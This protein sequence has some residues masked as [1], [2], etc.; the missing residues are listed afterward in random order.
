LVRPQTPTNTTV[1]IYDELGRLKAVITPSGDAAIY[2]YDAAGNIVSI[3]RQTTATVS[4]I[5]FT[6]DKGAVGTSVTIY[7]TGFSLTPT[8]NSVSFNG[9]AA[10]V[11][12]ASATQLIVAVPAGA[13]TGPITVTT[14]NGSATS[15]TSFEVFQSLSITGFT[16]VIGTPGNAVQING[17]GFDPVAAN[18]QLKFNIT[19]A[20]AGSAT[21]TTIDTTVPTG[22]TSGHI[23][24]TTGAGTAVSTAD[25][26]VPPSPF[27]AA[28]VDFTGRIALGE[29]KPLSVV[30]A[31]HIAL[32]VFD[33]TA[34]QRIAFQATNSTI[35]S[36][37]VTVMNP[38]G[39]NLLNPTSFSGNWF[40][41]PLT[42]PVTGTYTIVV[43]PNSTFTGT[44]NL[45]LLTV[46]VDISGTIAPGVP[47]TITPTPGQNATLTFNATAGDRIS[48]DL[49]N[50][51][52]S[53]SSVTV[54]KPD[55]TTLLSNA[56][57]GT[58]GVFF[59]ATTL[60]VSGSY[61]IFIDPKFAASGS[62][63][64]GLYMPVDT[65]GT[66]VI[67][68][69]PVV[70]TIASPGQNAQLT[71]TG[72]AGQ[73]IEV[74]WFGEVSFS[75]RP[76]ILKPDGTQLADDYG[77]STG[78][79]IYQLPVTG[80]YTILIDPLGNSAGSTTRIL[81]EIP[82][83]VTASIVADG[84]PITVAIPATGQIA[85]VTF[86][87]TAGQR[88]SLKMNNVKIGQSYADVV[89]T[90]PQGNYINDDFAYPEWFFDGGFLDIE[91]L[92]DTMTLP[93]TGTYTITIYPD[94]SS[95]KLD[96]QLFNVP[97]DVTGTI[98]PDGQPV[99]ITTTVPGQDARLTFT[100]TAGQR[101]TLKVTG[102][103]YPYSELYMLKPDGA[104]LS[105]FGLFTQ[106]PTTGAP[107]EGFEDTF[108]LP[109]AGTYTIV[110][111]GYL[112]FPGTT[113]M[114]LYDVPVLATGTGTIG[115][116][117]ATI[118]ATVP[119][120]DGEVTFNGTAGQ[121]F[122][123]KVTG[124]IAADLSILRPNG[125]TLASVRSIRQ[126]GPTQA[127]LF[128]AIVLPTTG[129][130]KI[131]VDTWKTA[132]TYTF[133]LYEVPADVSDGTISIGGSPV[134][135][136]ATA[137]RQN[138][139]LTFTGT[140]GQTVYLKI[141]NNNSWLNLVSIIRPD[142]VQ[143]NRR[144]ADN[145]ASKI[146]E[147]TTLPTTGTYTILTELFGTDDSVTLTL[148]QGSSDITETIAVDGQPVT[149][150]VPTSRQAAK[151]T[152]NV[153]AGQRT[154]L[155]RSDVTMPAGNVTAGVDLECCSQ[156]LVHAGQPG[157]FSLYQWAN[158]NTQVVSVRPNF[159][160]TGGVTVRLFDVPP[161]LT[162]TLTINGSPVTLTTTTPGQN[163]KLTMD[164]S[165]GQ[166][167]TLHI[168][169]NTVGKI[170]IEITKPSVSELPLTYY[171]DSGASF[172]LTPVVLPTPGT[173][174]VSVNP[175]RANMG[176][177]TISA[178][179]P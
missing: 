23:S 55:G 10:T 113:T 123:L 44:M 47:V 166:Q 124:P 177:V 43:D 40:V 31:N 33:G 137:E 119:G 164:G 15:T 173:Y 59:D 117:P 17:T 22:A 106:P 80:T 78:D 4:I 93:V 68:G 18:D 26:F 67:G 116:P 74:D 70:V 81:A 163:A 141:D 129:T 148:G 20:T 167:V 36:S 99:S 69:P 77:F 72:T 1:Y 2:N 35:S 149:I 102:A 107:P 7:G 134:T 127:E 172:D 48:L 34:G 9:V 12:A 115:G 24:V 29:T 11:T 160:F 120:H 136:T 42:L 111:N 105:T 98:L 133:N 109:T 86:S 27:T 50:V 175:W 168:T 14:P 91:R 87:G 13:S 32:I 39:S 8:Q 157:G 3:T 122:S 49:T 128:E 76:T 25:F 104:R 112:A 19:T 84:P 169:N 66:I 45:T 101:L 16:P 65:T 179:S 64:V 75:G 71:F 63:T 140:A 144:L 176:T 51:T 147:T 92:L 30:A 151:Y 132:G 153:T 103:I 56:N 73:I 28:S 52:I 121:K 161:D 150:N 159:D 85:K 82:Q 158:T 146:I 152:F 170:T 154:A 89:V 114:S 174:R 138:R 6:P 155:Q 21:S 61:S 54:R 110:V 62:M 60:P 79:D 126:I 142:G 58:A 97:A 38:D 83:P 171:L 108:T 178:T 53:S 118:T 100:G 88:V 156:E 90:D 37:T 5:E 125:Q 143:L 165:T 135:V 95:G 139:T 46:P 41:D 131:K 57:V 130:Y 96:L 145:A 94:S 162:G